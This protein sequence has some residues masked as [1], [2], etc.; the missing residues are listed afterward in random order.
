MYLSIY[1]Y[2]T[3]SYPSSCK[4]EHI[5][6]SIYAHALVYTHYVYMIERLRLTAAAMDA[7]GS[8]E[9]AQVHRNRYIYRVN[10]MSRANPIFELPIYMSIYAC[11]HISVRVNLTLFVAE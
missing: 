11:S 6:L 9:V 2:S 3:S 7:S 4:C 8:A 5:R 10:S 1:F